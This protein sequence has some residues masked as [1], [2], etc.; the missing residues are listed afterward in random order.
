VSLSAGINYC[1]GVIVTG[2]KIIAGVI[3]TGYKIIAG[4]VVT[5]YKLSPVPRT[6]V[7]NLLPV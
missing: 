7:I 6:P 3:V 1:R 2:Y 5:G 4:V